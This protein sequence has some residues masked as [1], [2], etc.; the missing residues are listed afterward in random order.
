MMK[1]I[2]ALTVLA[3]AMTLFVAWGVFHFTPQGG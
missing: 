3:G 2:V 1:L